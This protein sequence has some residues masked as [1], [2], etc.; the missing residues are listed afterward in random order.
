MGGR[1]E[2]GRAWEHWGGQQGGSTGE[3]KGTWGDRCVHRPDGLTG[4]CG[5][6]RERAS[7][8]ARENASNYTPQYLQFTAHQLYVHK[9]VKTK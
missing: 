1:L 5:G 9:A 4:V 7:K 3:T 2:R 6:V 8:R